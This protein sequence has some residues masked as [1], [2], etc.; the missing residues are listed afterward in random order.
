VKS[1]PPSHSEFSAVHV[2]RKHSVYSLV[3]R[4]QCTFWVLAA[5]KWMCTLTQG[6]RQYLTACGEILGKHMGC[7]PCLIQRIIRSISIRSRQYSFS[8]LNGLRSPVYN[9]VKNIWG[10]PCKGTEQA[11]TR[12][13]KFNSC[14][15]ILPSGKYKVL[16]FG[17]L[18]M[19]LFKQ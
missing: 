12:E 14:A 7:S 11:N 18:Y 1:F 15:S 2:Q 16:G 13:G 17:H 5:P 9:L 19:V 4:M 6:T 8:S 10:C 3:G